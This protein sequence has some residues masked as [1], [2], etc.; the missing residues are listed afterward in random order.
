MIVSVFLSDFPKS[1]LHNTPMPSAG[2]EKPNIMRAT[3]FAIG[4]RTIAG[5][6][7]IAYACG[8]KSEATAQTKITENAHL[9]YNIKYT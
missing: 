1:L 4:M 2:N 7:I 5:R 6:K 3:I 9:I 8:T